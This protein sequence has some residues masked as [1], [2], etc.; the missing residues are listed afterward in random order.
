VQQSSPDRHTEPGS[1]FDANLERFVNETRQHGGIPV[2]MNAVV[3]R[4]N[5]QGSTD[6][7][8]LSNK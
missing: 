4:C 8:T 3:R 1:S 6:A 2:L 5:M 7:E